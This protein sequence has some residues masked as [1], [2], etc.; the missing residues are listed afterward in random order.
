MENL[1][2]IRNFVI[3]AHIDHGKST[4]ADRLLEATGTVEARRM[5]PQY[6]DQLELER[7]RG[8]T[9][10][11]APVRMLYKYPAQMV[12]DD[13]Q[14]SAD[15][16]K[17]LY[18]DLTY[19][20]RGAAFEVWNKI[21]PGFR[22]SIYQKSL[23]AELKK[24]GIDF[25]TQP[26]LKIE[27][28]NKAVGDYRPDLVID[29]KVLVELKA[30]PFIG[31]T[32]K[33][34]VWSYLKG[35]SYKL[36]LLINFGPKKVEVERIVYDSVRNL[37]SSASY[38]R[39]SAQ[40]E[41][42]LN[43][44]DTPGHSD[45]SYEVSRALAAV[46]GAVLLVDAT[47]GIQAQ[48]LSNFRAARKAGLKIIGAVN[49]I[50]LLHTQTN[51]DG[52]PSL[53][54][55]ASRGGQTNAELN[56]MINELAGLIG[57]QAKEILL[58]SGKTGRGVKELLETIVEKVP[59]PNYA[60]QRGLNA[61]PRLDGESRRA[62]QRGNNPRKLVSS[63]RES[64]APSR[65][66]IFDSLYDDH[67]GIIAFIRI[68]YGGLKAGD[69]VKLLATNTKCKIKE[70]GYFT[71]QLKSSEGIF[72][73]EI[74][75]IAT[76]IKEPALV[77]IG[78]TIFANPREISTRNNANIIGE[79]S[80]I[81]SQS[82]ASCALPG[83][84]E[85][86]P[87][88]FVSLYPDGETQFEDLKKAFERLRLTDSALMFEPDSSEAL[89]RGL[90]VGFLGQLHFEIATS[91]LEREFG[92]QFMASFPSTAYRVKTKGKFTTIKDP[93][94]FPDDAD[95]V[96]Q[97]MMRVEVFSPPEYLSQIL[98]IKENFHMEI[99]EIKNL[100]NNVIIEAEM[101]LAELVRNFDDKIKSLSS[102]YASFSYEVSGESP[103]KVEK[104][105]IMVNDEPVSALTRIVFKDEAESE[106]RTTVER[107]KELLPK[108]QFTQAIQAKVRGRIIARETI[109][110]MRKDVTGYLY[111]GD[112]TRKMKLWKK[113]KRGKEKLKG[114]SRVV[115]PT[116]VFRDLLKK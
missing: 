23:E 35:S 40:I 6:L 80:R 49:K 105:E 90:K 113:Q 36:A 100:G 94:D 24:Q 27:Y 75:Y 5:K 39:S 116:E 77:K 114:M 103:A 4:L 7:E 21:G 57:C 52:T 54:L 68:F 26:T 85:P 104:L 11:M 20:I 96:F 62:D 42:I 38:P 45:F 87:V 74:G 15:N 111:G 76:G 78:D 30:L 102:G 108:Q 19:K 48:T 65:A 91:R 89:G 115:V 17:F 55:T 69:E 88:I 58:V 101:P 64:A 83:Y 10:K 81:S 107:L 98:S 16:E 109:A 44:I 61:Q 25:V 86:A 18:G 82:L 95:E 72:E 33:K 2:N 97:P 56:R 112:R 32:E 8:I 31:D 28:E 99:F 60:D 84:K 12:A 71:P 70:I 37:R 92:L 14:I 34:Q 63:P 106:G 1:K 51:A 66:L 67:K 47:K 29:D 53:A 3:I 22:E 79:V 9:I 59:P 41:Y 46:E 13:T 93:N 50:D 43:L 110:A 73:G